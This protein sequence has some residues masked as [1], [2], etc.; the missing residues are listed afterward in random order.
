MHYV[1]TAERQII[2]LS[3][4]DVST[5]NLSIMTK[6]E[7][8]VQSHM[9]NVH[10]YLLIITNQCSPIKLNTKSLPKWSNP[11]KNEE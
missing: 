5:F 6:A 3:S 8:I 2:K 4:K 11:N 10:Y 1:S 7:I 9:C